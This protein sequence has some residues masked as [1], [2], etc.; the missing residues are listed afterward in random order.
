MAGAGLQVADGLA[1]LGEQGEAGMPQIVEADGG[2]PPAIA[3]NIEY[4]AGFPPLWPDLELL[5]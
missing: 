3:V 4:E 5:L 2:D 1:A